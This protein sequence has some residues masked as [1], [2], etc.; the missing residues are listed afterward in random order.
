MYICNKHLVH[1]N[2][3]QHRYDKFSDL[4]LTTAFGT[5]NQRRWL[6][7]AQF[8]L[9][10]SELSVS[11]N[12]GLYLFFER[13]QLAP[14]DLNSSPNTLKVLGITAAR[15]YNGKRQLVLE[16]FFDDFVFCT[17]NLNF[18]RICGY[19]LPSLFFLVTKKK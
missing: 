10:L 9:G 3:V 2:I 18:A 4:Y 8:I 6:F 11:V 19:R 15:K 7:I 16:M 14:L 5:A 1:Y 12:V 17:A 13:E